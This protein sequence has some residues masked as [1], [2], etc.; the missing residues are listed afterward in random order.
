[1]C[2]TEPLR[3]ERD[4]LSRGNDEPPSR[5]VPTGPVDHTKTTPTDTPCLVVPVANVSKALS[6]DTIFTCQT[7]PFL[8]ARILKILELVQIGE[9][10]T[11][12]QCE[13]VKSIISKFTDCFALSLNEVDLIPG[14][15]HKLNIP[16]DATFRTKIP[17]HSFNLD[18]CAFMEVKVNEMLKGGIIHS[19]HPR[20]VKCVAPSVLAQKT[21][22]N[23]GLSSD[24]LKH[25]VNE[26]CVKHGLP[27]TFDLPPCPPPSEG[28]PTAT[29]PKKWCLCQD[30]SEI[31]KVMP[32]A[33]VPQ[34]NIHAKQ[35]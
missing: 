9:D 26:E 17:Q 1:M 24:K 28:L 16:E 20:D 14:A 35:L 7:N 25:K 8:P 12:A 11:A 33:P 4:D 23:T 22:E 15:I 10:I 30:F 29:S 5:G 2:Q 6:E 32:I 21:H 13:E 18:Q 3:V 19:I 34:G 31:N 27:T